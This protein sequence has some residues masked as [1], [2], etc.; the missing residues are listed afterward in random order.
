MVEITLMTE[1][2]CCVPNTEF[3]GYEGEADCNKLVFQFADGFIDGVGKLHTKEGYYK[4]YKVDNKYILPI[5]KEMLT[6]P[7]NVTFQLEIETKDGKIYRYDE[8]TMTIKPST[9]GGTEIE[10]PNI[11][12]SEQIEDLT[13]NMSIINENGNLIIELP[14][15]YDIVFQRN[16]TDELMVNEAYENITFV[17]NN[18]ELEMII[19]GKI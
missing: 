9:N 4:L 13:N 19:D 11:L 5:K 7:K 2:R 1:N 17:N 16:E 10:Q 3:L 12:I 18:N 15:T 8:F 6:E 14:S